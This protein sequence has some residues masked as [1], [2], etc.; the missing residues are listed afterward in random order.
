MTT[1][2]S[3]PHQQSV[4]RPHQPQMMTPQAAEMIQPPMAP[5]R[6]Q[7]PITQGVT[8]IR[9]MKSH[10]GVDLPDHVPSPDLHFLSDLADLS[11]LDEEEGDG[12]LFHVQEVEGDDPWS[13]HPRTFDVTTDLATTVA[14]VPHGSPTHVFNASCAQTEPETAHTDLRRKET[15]PAT[16][17]EK[18]GTTTP[19]PSK[20]QEPSLTANTQTEICDGAELVNK[21][22]VRY[23][24]KAYLLTFPRNNTP[25]QVVADRLLSSWRNDID[26]FVVAQEAH[27]DGTPHLHVV[28][29]FKVRKEVRQATF[30][31]FLSENGLS[32]ANHCNIQ[33]IRSR[34]GAVVYVTKSDSSPVTY[35]DVPKPK[36]PKGGGRKPA[37][38]KGPKVTKK[39]YDYFK[40]GKTLQEIHADEDCGPFMMVNMAKMKDYATWL[41]VEKAKSRGPGPKITFNTQCDDTSCQ[42]V[43]AWLEKNLNHPRM[44]KQKQLYIMGKPN[45]GKTTLLEKLRLHYRVFE[46]PSDDKRFN[47]WDDDAYDIAVMDEFKG[48][49]PLT[50]LNK[51]LD[52]QHMKLSALYSSG[53]R[54]SKNIPMIFCSNFS[55][56][57]AYY[58]QKPE[59][60]APFKIRLEIVDIPEGH[61]LDINLILPET[62][63][64]DEPITEQDE[65]PCIVEEPDIK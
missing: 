54:K 64:R 47:D 4:G 26:F 33:T 24:A 38:E 51:W 30:F 58:N 5:A 34:L 32:K 36:P 8:P 21:P 19:G 16:F 11:F 39:I 28:I 3:M 14:H 55:P 25:K 41:A 52:G 57:E 59:A 60:L 35:G 10:I 62:P 61:M 22:N 37:A 9:S 50:F 29:T 31:D 13:L 49:L 48:Q 42:E 18:G 45:S 56:E 12:D 40:A 6:T 43:C 27:Q 44:F 63:E 23:Y 20:E 65:S 17:L 1:L 46:M 15:S 2:G 53:V 7:R